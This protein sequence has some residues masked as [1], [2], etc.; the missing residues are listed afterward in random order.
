MCTLIFVC[1]I[2]LILCSTH[3]TN[4]P[5]FPYLPHHPIYLLNQSI[6]FPWSTSKWNYLVSF[7]YQSTCYIYILFYL[8]T[9]S[10]VC[11]IYFI[12]WSTRFTNV[13]HFLY[14]LHHPIYL[15]N[16]S[17]FFLDLF[18]KEHTLF[19]YSKYLMCQSICYTNLSYFDSLPYPPCVPSTSFYGLPVTN[20]PRFSYLSHH[21][22]YLLNQFTCFFL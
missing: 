9:L 10:S 20:I 1:T 14:L 22:V 21:P 11:T 18:Q 12:L 4:I 8:S 6:F 16:Q 15:L 3:F 5:R 13:P 2:Y 7:I 17:T 19:H